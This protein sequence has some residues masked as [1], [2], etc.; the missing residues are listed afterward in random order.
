M[1]QR[2]GKEHGSK[3]EQANDR[4]DQRGGEHSGSRKIF[5]ATN[6]WRVNSFGVQKLL[7][8][9]I[10]NFRDDNEPYGKDHQCP[11]CQVKTH[12]KP[13][14]DNQQSNDQM[15]EDF[16]GAERFPRTAKRVPKA[17]PHVGYAKRRA[18]SF[19]MRE[20]SLGRV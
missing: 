2:S 3:D 10:E 8:C 16:W 5:G 19:S 6:G 11:L 12:K 17:I 18:V 15:P 1:R 14:R 7:N 13:R 20:A 9:R 4:P